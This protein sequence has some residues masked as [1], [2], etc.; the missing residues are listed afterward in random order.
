MNGSRRSFH[1]PITTAAI[2]MLLTNAL[3][4]SRLRYLSWSPGLRVCDSP[5]PAKPSCLPSA[6]T[7]RP[8]KRRPANSRLVDFSR[9]DID[10]R[11]FRGRSRSLGYSLAPSDTTHGQSATLYESHTS[12]YSPCFVRILGDRPHNDSP[13]ARYRLARSNFSGPTCRRWHIRSDHGESNSPQ[14]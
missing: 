2:G 11:Q 6:Y 9:A 1:S 3:P 7:G 4:T 14:C 5:F 10:E 13:Q 12:R 8:R